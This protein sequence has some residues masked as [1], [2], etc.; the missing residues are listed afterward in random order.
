VNHQ[1]AATS[2]G[3]HEL[4]I[5]P[6]WPLKPIIPRKFAI[7]FEENPVDA[8]QNQRRL[9]NKGD[10][11][12]DRLHSRAP[13]APAGRDAQIAGGRVQPHEHPAVGV[14]AS[15]DHPPRQVRQCP[16]LHRL[17]LVLAHR[18]WMTTSLSVAVAGFAAVTRITMGIG[19]LRILS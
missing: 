3:D 10:A 5:P 19:P 14:F 17:M 16:N 6:V 12:P 11:P 4:R 18:T 2:L 8:R 13:A 15:H 1:R 7:R 9:A